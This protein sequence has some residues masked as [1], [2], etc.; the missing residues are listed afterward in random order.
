[1]ATAGKGIETAAGLP[2]RSV[3]VTV[4][5]AVVG[6]AAFGVPRMTPVVPSMLSPEGRS[7]AAYEAMSLAVGLG[8]MAVSAT[9]TCRVAGGV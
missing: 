4:A 9:P 8:I 6:L 3:T 1:M 2:A 7:V 5:V